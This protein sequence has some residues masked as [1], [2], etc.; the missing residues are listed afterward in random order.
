MES[1]KQRVKILGKLRKR[2][3]GTEL[4][5]KLSTFPEVVVLILFAF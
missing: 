4:E 1:L 2:D 3:L 5:L